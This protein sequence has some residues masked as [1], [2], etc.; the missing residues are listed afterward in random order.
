MP[1]GE[2]VPPT[3]FPEDEPLVC[4][5]INRDWLPYL[6]GALRPMQYPEYWAG[7]LEEN[8]HAR[9]AAKNLMDKLEQIQECG[10][11]S[12][13]CGCPDTRIVLERIDPITFQLQ[14][15]VDGGTTWTN[16]PNAVESQIVS[17]P[18]PVPA[19]RSANKC[20]AATNGWEHI[21][22]LV[23]KVSDDLGT[24]TT[25]FEL[26][27]ACVTA[28]IDILLIT[29]TGGVALPALIAGLGAAILAAAQ[30]VFELGKEGFDTFWDNT[31]RDHVLCA[32]YCNISEDGQFTQAG[33]D[34]FKQDYNALIPAS[35]ARDMVLAEIKGIG[36]RGLNQICAYGTA[37]DADCLGCN[38]GCDLTHWTIVNGTLVSRTDTQ[39]VVQSENVDGTW[40]AEIRAATP[41]NGCMFLT[42]TT[43]IEASTTIEWNTRGEPFTN[44]MPFPLNH[45]G[46]GAEDACINT[47]LVFGFNN[48][49]IG[50]VT[51]NTS[52]ECP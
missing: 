48:A 12:A 51:F 46:L 35:P 19:G 43:S 7:T 38:C 31:N 15:S 23:A 32:L 9:R 52:N 2:I 13:D 29:V 44:P 16:S 37:A 22:D 47:F 5:S 20:D 18:P 8:R 30:A 40:G 4:L 26:V 25:I 11:M 41:S 21:M 24:A 36:L 39:I 42:P 1:I 50:Q 27:T 28:L 45:G 10:D 6:V 3:T 49:E 17:Q 14:V 33:Y 34:A